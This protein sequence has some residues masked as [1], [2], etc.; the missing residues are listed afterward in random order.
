[1]KQDEDVK[2]WI[3]YWNSLKGSSNEKSDLEQAESWNKRWGRPIDGMGN[4]RFAGEKQ[5]RVE[6][7]FKML[8]E[9]G[10]EVNGARVLDIGSGTGAV[11][12]PFAKAGARVTALDVSSTALERLR[13]DA[14]KEGLSI[15]T[16]E[17]SWWTADIDKL[18]IRSKFDLVI[19]TSTPAVKDADGFDRMMSCSNDL[20]YYSFFIQNGRNAQRDYEVIFRKILKKEPPGRP[21]GRGAL[22]I[23]GFMYLYLAGYRPLI[24]VKHN[25]R[26]VVMDWSEAADDTIRFLEFS[27]PFTPATKDA[28]REYYRSSAVDG[29]CHAHHDGY[30]GAM[31]W[32]VNS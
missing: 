27:E 19:A 22:F 11:A 7:M 2:I 32:K 1:M 14:E 28:I 6:E 17:R 30:S 13:A 10:F 8:H 12:I 18:G 29:K 31:V 26:D 16:V 20:C 21:I 5:K 24:R 3:D 15:E 4:G 23:N 25:Q 9:E